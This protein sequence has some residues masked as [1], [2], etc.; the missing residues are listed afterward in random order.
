MASGN[1]G[2]S[3][4]NQ[5]IVGNMSWSS[6]TNVAENY[7]DVYAELRTWRT[8]SGYTTTGTGN[9]T[10]S[11]D[12]QQKNESNAVT[13]TQNS[14][15]FII[16]HSARVY[17][18]SDGSKAIDITVS[19]GIGGTSYTATY[20]GSAVQLDT[21]PRASQPTLSNGNFDIGSTITVYMNRVSSSFTHNVTWGYGTQT[22]TIATDVTDQVNWTSPL[23]MCQMTPASIQGYGVIYVD[24]Y[25]GGTYIGQKTVGFYANVPASVVPTIS[26]VGTSELTTSPNVATI[27]GKYVQ[28]ISSIRMTVNGATGYYSATVPTFKLNLNGKDFTNNGNVVDYGSADFTGINVLTA[29]AIDSRGRSSA[30]KTVNVEVLPYANPLIVSFTAQR[31]DSG[32]TLNELGDYVKIVRRGTATSLMNTT[33][34]NTVACKVYYRERPTTTW[35][36]ATACTVAA[37]SSVSTAVGAT[38][39]VLDI[40]G[41]TTGGGF[42]ILKAYDFKMELTDK[43]YTTISQTV[44]SVGTVV[45]SLG[46]DGVGIGKIWQSG[47]LD[48][49]GNIV[50][51][52]RILGG[53]IFPKYGYVYTNGYLVATDIP[54]NSDSMINGIISCNGYSTDK[55][56]HIVFHA[57]NYTSG[58]QIINYS[59]VALDYSTP[60][61]MFNYNGYV[62][63]WISSPTT[64]ATV[65]FYV[66]IGDEYNRV[67]SITNAVKPTSG[68]TREVTINPKQVWHSG[69][70][71]FSNTSPGWCKDAYGLVTQWG[72][73]YITVSGGQ[74]SARIT[75][76]IQYPN[77]TPLAC[78]I[79]PLDVASLS[80]YR[81]TAATSG[82]DSTGVNAYVSDTGLGGT[83]ACNVSFITMGL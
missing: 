29:Y 31:C 19:G 47:A 48:V 32:G 40:N 75:F 61:S 5:Y 43:F 77:L 21:I 7:S 18:N 59:A 67:T 1:I 80:I 46:S 79:T 66:S 12:G 17:H 57:Y 81:L 55:N 50:L 30:S 65:K 28:G 3:S 45:M 10:I 25:S 38:A 33:E 2:A 68:V 52:G 73:A 13:L 78:V 27:V 76:P 72:S 74:G 9:W 20:C 14:N 70:N 4:N 26:S 15:T 24:T 35:I 39:I 11:I 60:I 44:V 16:S 37:S 8:N 51:D 54:A 41:A 83:G 82:L 58:N 53:G 34:R 23:T 22:G 69:N 36:E 63:F 62:Y 71:S 56:L 49:K 6:S 64:Y 42:D